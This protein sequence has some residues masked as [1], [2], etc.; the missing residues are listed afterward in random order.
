MLG[1]GFHWAHVAVESKNAHWIIIFFIMNPQSVIVPFQ[2]DDLNSFYGF[3]FKEVNPIVLY[4]IK[5][6]NHSVGIVRLQTSW[7]FN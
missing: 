5:I 2:F 1:L 7:T 3:D 4:F 6:Q